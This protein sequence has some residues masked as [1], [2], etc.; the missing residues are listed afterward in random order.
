MLISARMGQ[1]RLSGKI[2]SRFVAIQSPLNM[3]T[4]IYHCSLFKS[5]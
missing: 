5:N 4:E 3:I 2:L 1:L